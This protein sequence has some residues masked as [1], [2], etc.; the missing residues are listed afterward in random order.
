MES[1]YELDHETAQLLYMER[2]ITEEKLSKVQKLFCAW[3]KDDT[4]ITDKLIDIIDIL[5]ARL[6]DF[7]PDDDH[8]F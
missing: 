5:E 1:N 7:G 8:D 2:L 6:D 4:E 3:D